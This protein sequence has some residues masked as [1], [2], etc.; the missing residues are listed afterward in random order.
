MSGAKHH[1]SV[2]AAGVPLMLRTSPGNL[3]D[4]KMFATMLD[5]IA[6][7]SDG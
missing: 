5:A 4:S 6:P 3:H 2:D 7:V 1:L